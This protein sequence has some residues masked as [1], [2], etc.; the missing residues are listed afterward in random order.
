MFSCVIRWVETEIQIIPIA[1]HPTL[2]SIPASDASPI[3][4]EIDKYKQ[5]LKDCYAQHGAVPVT[6]EVGR[7]AG[8]GG[9]A[10][11][12]VVPVPEELAE[13]VET[14]FRKAGEAQGI[15]WEAEPELALEKAG[16]TANYFKVELPNGSMMVH[17]LRGGFDLQFG[18]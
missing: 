2:L 10:H 14:A 7:L 4:S 15:D 16:K 13:Q 17:M 5:S 9:H 3:I 11:V 12:Q 18:R 8:R 1:H 6:W